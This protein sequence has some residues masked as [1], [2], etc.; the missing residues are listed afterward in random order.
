MSMKDPAANAVPLFEPSVG[1]KPFRYPWAYDYWKRQQHVHW[2]ASDVPLGEDCK[3]WVQLTDQERDL[4]TQVFRFFTQADIDVADNYMDRLGQ[5][6]RPTEIRMMLSAF[7]A[8]ETIHVDAYSSLIETIG[9]DESEYSAFMGYAAMRGKHDFSARFS[10]ANPRELLLTLAVFGGFIEGVQLFAS[11]AILASFPKRGLMR[12]MGQIVSYSVRDES[13]HCDGVCRLFRQLR[14]EM[15]FTE[16][17]DRYLEKWVRRYGEE[18]VRLE[19]EFIDS[20]F[21]LAPKGLDN[22]KASEVK[23]YVDWVAAGRYDQL[24]V[25][26][27]KRLLDVDLSSHPLPWLPEVLEAMEHANFFEVKATEYGRGNVSGWEPAFDAFDRS[28]GRVVT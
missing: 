11:F 27:P 15:A 3:D 19:H 23:R 9:M 6:F 5:A 2:L 26:R 24:G 21:R 28:M 20:A 25:R 10:A 1:Y 8:M 13:L 16:V 17:E 12:G 7:S 14:S 4:L 18:A 22:L